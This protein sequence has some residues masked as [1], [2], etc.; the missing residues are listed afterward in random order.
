ML[1]I[2]T[3]AAYY[4]HYHKLANVASVLA[5]MQGECYVATYAL[6]PLWQSVALLLQCRLQMHAHK[7]ASQTYDFASVRSPAQQA[8]TVL[9]TKGMPVFLLQS[10]ISSHIDAVDP[11][12]GLSITGP[13]RVRA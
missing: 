4:Y 11:R 10:H 12:G 1:C 9:M 6:A 8:C 3:K 5:C 2:D 13:V 7:E